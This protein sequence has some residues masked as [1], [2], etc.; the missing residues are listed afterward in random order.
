MSPAHSKPETSLDEQRRYF[1]SER[2][3]LTV[4]L[5]LGAWSLLVAYSFH[6]NQSLLLKEKIALATS[7]ARS[8]W[9]KDQAFRVWA[10]KHGGVYVPPTAATPPNPNLAHVPDRDIETTNGIRLTLMNPAYMMRQM[11]EDF[12]QTYGVKGKITGLRYLNPINAPDEWERRILDRYVAGDA[13]EVAEQAVIDGQPFLRYMKPMYMKEGCDKCHAIL[14]YK[15]GDLRGGVSV[16]VPL[17]PY[18]DAAR[19]SDRSMLATHI[20]VWLIGVIG[21]LLFTWQAARKSRERSKLLAQLEQAALYDRLTGLPTRMLFEDRI[22]HALHARPGTTDSGFAVCFVDLDRFKQINDTY[23]HAMGDRLLIQVGRVLCGAARANDTVARLGGDE[24]VVLLNGIDSVSQAVDI[25][26]RLLTALQAPFDINGQTI[27]LDVSIGIALH[28]SPLDTPDT[29]I[30]H[31]DIAMFR[32]KRSSDQNIA[33]FNTDMH[34]RIRE[35]TELEAALRS[36]LDN[37]EFSVFYQPIVDVSQQRVTGFEALLRWNNP[38]LGSVPPDLF[39]PVAEQIGLIHRIGGWVFEQACS[40]LQSW[41]KHFATH[42][43]PLTVSV[44][45]SAKQLINQHLVDD[46]RELLARTGLVPEQLC[47]EVTETAFVNEQDQAQRCLAGLRHLGCR[48]SADD[49]GTGYSSL[50]YLQRYDFD[51]YK[52]DKQFVQDHSDT[53]AGMKLCS[54]L[55]GLADDLGLAVVAEGVETYEQCIRLQKMGCTCMQGYYFSRPLPSHEIEAL[56]ERGLH[57]DISRLAA[58]AA[59]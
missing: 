19:K 5:L 43:Q 32:A 16:S 35:M 33:V 48:L 17:A 31:A 12:E 45:L 40:Q 57:L 34:A 3:F 38:K 21:L 23:G 18:F 54:A 55:I 44:N 14:G 8:L 20:G 4:A 47:F 58:Y 28:E 51:S 42:S 11:T 9:N 22:V 15:T 6:W 25:A 56:L 59:A 37:D 36:A 53:G 39:I 27:Q 46:V 13:Q 29:L 10:S 30:Q 52:I 41:Q 26:K 1:L 7:E 2:I 49:F 24:Y 50:T